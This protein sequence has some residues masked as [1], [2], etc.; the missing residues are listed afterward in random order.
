MNTLKNSIKQALWGLVALLLLFEEW[1]WQGLSAALKEMGKWPLVAALERGL[2]RLPPWAALCVLG[3]PA[4]SLFPLKLVAIAL[5]ANG[6]ATAGLLFLLGLKVL[7]TALVARLFQLTEPA[8]M[9]LGWFAKYYP[10]FVAWKETVFARIRLS[11]AWRVGRL[12]KR[13][14]HHQWLQWMQKPPS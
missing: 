3:A 7:G 14:V 9:Q 2:K 6:H 10:R 4:I 13:R 5:F 1:G 11:L 12:I 8:L